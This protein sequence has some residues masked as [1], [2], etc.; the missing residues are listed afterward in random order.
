M[1]AGTQH[2]VK[3]QQIA[4][5]ENEGDEGSLLSL[6]VNQTAVLA[7]KGKSEQIQTFD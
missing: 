4:V 7:I 5:R 3:M 6:S 1:R 2:R